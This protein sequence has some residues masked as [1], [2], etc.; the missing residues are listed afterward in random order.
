MKRWP[1]G[2]AAI[3]AA[4]V[5]G[6]WGSSSLPEDSRSFEL[7]AVDGSALSS[8]EAFSGSPYLIT[9]GYTFCPDVCPT[10]L[11]YL[12]TVMEA[13]EERNG[14][15]LNAVFVSVD[16]QR[17]T[18]E[19]LGQYV[20]FFGGGIIGATGTPEQLAATSKTYSVYFE[21]VP[22]RDDENY[23]IDHSAGIL[24]LDD[25]HRLRGVLRE[26]ESLDQAL[27]TLAELL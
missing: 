13:Y 11:A 24:V 23:L 21:R 4:F 8:A 17:D 2:V 12:S 18:P 25:K 16:P 15:R 1:L 7:T 3:A 14:E 27:G 22:G 9:F 10:T 6:F 26:G 5:L 19:R 20:E